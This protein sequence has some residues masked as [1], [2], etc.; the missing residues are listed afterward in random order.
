M[1]RKCVEIYLH[2]SKRI[3]CRLPTSFKNLA[4]GQAYGRHLH[5]L[6]CRFSKRSQSHG[7][8]FLRNRPEME[9]M[10]RL[11]NEKAEGAT[12]ALSVLACSKG[13]EVYSILWSVRTFRPDLRVIVQAVD[14]SRDIIDFA[15]KGAYSLS[16]PGDPRTLDHLGTIDEEQLIWATY[17]DQGVA[18]NESI[19][20]RMDK[21]E[22]SAVFD[23]EEGQAKVKRWLKEGITWRVGDATAPGLIDE[24]GLQDIVV[25]NRFLCHMDVPAAESCLRNIAGL[26]KP[27][28]YI[29]VSGVDLDVR[30]KV[31]KEMN[32]Q[33]V[34]DLI[35]EIHEGDTSLAKG[36]PFHWWGLEPFS[37]KH[38]DW[39]SR[40]ASVFQVGQPELFTL[41]RAAADVVGSV[42]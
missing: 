14:I 25:A 11:L 1:V 2:Q 19:F 40:Y 26:V 39:R 36:W 24:L 23:R 42:T 20:E 35:K 32:W 10:C 9:L 15:E 8:F 3:W 5:A 22:M 33:P 16:C 31:A 28:G 18:Q 17:R 38:P 37:E 41:D 34:S 4:I 6:V 12:V 7:T 29:F 21:S 27:G 30:T 13:A